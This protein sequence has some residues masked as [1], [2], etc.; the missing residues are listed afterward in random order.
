MREINKFFVHC[1][2]TRPSQNVDAEWIRNIHVSEKGWDDIGYHDVILRDGSV[3]PGR[4][5]H[6]A[7]AHARGHNSTSIA[8]CLVG[9]M[10]ED[11]K[12]ECNFTLAQYLTLDFLY[13]QKCAEIGPLEVFGHNEVSEKPCPCF[14]AKE[15]LKES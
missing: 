14:N 3:E 6:I 4:P 2:Y 10:S 1:S 13:K 12:P 11:G 7:G 15:L 8:V 5:I 9:G